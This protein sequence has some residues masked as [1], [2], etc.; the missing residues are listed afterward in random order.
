MARVGSCTSSTLRVLRREYS[1][2]SMSCDNSLIIA[3]RLTELRYNLLSPLLSMPPDCII[4]MNEE[5][6]QLREENV[7]HLSNLAGSPTTSTTLN[8]PSQAERSQSE[9]FL[10]RNEPDGLRESRL[11]VFDGEHLDA[12]PED[13]ARELAIT[14]EQVLIQPEPSSERN[15][16]PT[17]YSFLLTISLCARRYSA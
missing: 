15:L 6:A 14:E 2:Y 13:V 16:S 5:G 7:I 9:S 1:P 17:F 10:R 11:Y 12:D 3:P 4:C 8:D